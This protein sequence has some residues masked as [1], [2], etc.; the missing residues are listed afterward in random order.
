[1]STT[2][3]P[4]IDE[5]RTI[6]EDELT[7]VNGTISDCHNDGT[8]LLLRAIV[9]EARHVRPKDA[10]QGG[11]AMAV[12]GPRICVHPYIVHQVCRNGAIM[13]QALETRVV[14]RLESQVPA[15]E[16]NGLIFRLR[17]AISECLSPAAFGVA[18]DQVRSATRQPA[19]SVLH[20]ILR[21]SLASE[22][23]DPV[24]LRRIEQRFRQAGERT[25]FGVMNAVT[26]VARDQHDPKVRW[27]LEELGGSV[28]ALLHPAS[29]PDGSAAYPRIQK[30]EKPYQRPSVAR[31]LSEPEAR[32]AGGATS[33]RLRR[34]DLVGSG[35]HSTTERR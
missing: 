10:V 34:L 3:L 30:R 19:S 20:V 27:C 2:L 26:S 4:A 18:V 13:V 14:E 25:V 11:I 23:R 7:R 5:I 24:L 17:A 8:R 12:A 21:L 22:A 6:A 32:I 9:P 15:D 16:V 35:S 33:Q 1:M 31:A 28:P 29:K